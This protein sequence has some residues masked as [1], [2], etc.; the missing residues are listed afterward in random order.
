[1]LAS[2]DARCAALWDVDNWK[3]AAA[4][5][6]FLVIATA[7]FHGYSALMADH[8]QVSIG[9]SKAF[10]VH[11]DRTFDPTSESYLLRLQACFSSACRP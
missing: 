5:A 9:G 11:H 1:M 2:T 6:L 7:I 8:N 10:E 3:R 4:G